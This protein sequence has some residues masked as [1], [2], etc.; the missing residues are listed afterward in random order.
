[1][2]FIGRIPDPQTANLALASQGRALG[3][4][5]RLL[6]VGGGDKHAP[7]PPHYA[8]WEHCLLDVVPGPDVDV[9]LDPRR[10]ASLEPEQFDAVYCAH[11]LERHHPHDI[12]KIL[13][14]LVHV[15]KPEGYVEIRTPDVMTVIKTVV[16]NRMEPDDVLYTSNAVPISAHDVIYGWGEAIATVGPERY[17]HKRGFSVRSLTASL[18]RARFTKVW[19][20]ITESRYEIRALAFKSEPSPK[21]EA[22]LG[23]LKRPPY[24]SA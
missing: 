8:G 18:D 20:L 23:P 3:G 2:V 4:G 11:V 22:F 13:A 5:L 16:I 12:P 14:G 17:A 9:V 15:L 21:Q 7:L 1:V 24:P 19:E 6:N 10:L